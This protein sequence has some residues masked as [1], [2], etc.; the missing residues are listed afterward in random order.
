MHKIHIM[1]A[2]KIIPKVLFIFIYF[3]ANAATHT[4]D[5]LHRLTSVV[6]N[7]SQRIDY[8]YDAAGNLIEER[9]N[10]SQGL[11]VSAQASPAAGGSVSISPVQ[12]GYVAGDTVTATATPSAGYTFTGW[13]G[14]SACT[15][16]SACTFTVPTSSVSL[17]ANFAAPSGL[18]PLRV[19]ALP[20]VGGT[21]TPS[22]NAAGYA[23]GTSITLTATPAAGYVIDY[24]YGAAC[25]NYSGPSCTFSMPAHSSD[26]FV[27]FKQAG[28]GYLLSYASSSP[29]AGVLDIL[30]SQDRIPA[31]AAV[32][33][34][35]LA[36]SGYRFSD[37]RFT[38]NGVYDY[39]I[40]STIQNFFFIPGET[41]TCTFN[42]PASDVAIDVYYTNDPDRYALDITAS[43]MNGGTT[44]ISVNPDTSFAYYYTE[45]SGTATKLLVAGGL[46][47]TLTAKPAGARAFVRWANGP[48]ANSTNPVCTFNMPAVAT[49]SNP[50]FGDEP[51]ASCTYSVSAPSLLFPGT[52][53]TKN[54]T[55][56]TQAG[57]NFNTE[58]YADGNPGFSVSNAGN[59]VTLTVLPHASDFGRRAMLRIHT[60]REVFNYSIAQAGNTSSTLVALSP[61]NLGSAAVGDIPTT[62]IPVTLTN[63]STFVQKMQSP[64]TSGPFAVTS[65]TCPATL[66][67]GASCV[68]NVQFV[69][70]KDGAPSGELLVGASRMAWSAALTATALPT[71]FNVA[72][73]LKGA[74][75]KAQARTG[76]VQYNESAVINGDRRG[77]YGFDQ[78]YWNV[79]AA[80][81]TEVQPIEIKFNSSQTVEW[82]YLFGFDAGNGYT[83]PYP[84]LINT[85]NQSNAGFTVEYWTGASWLAVSELLRVGSPNQWQRV[86]FTPVTTDRVRL[87]LTPSNTQIVVSEIEVWTVAS[88]I[89]PVAFTFAS[90]TDVVPSTVVTSAAVTPTGY[91]VA[92]P[93]SV[94]GGS[95]SIGCGGVF[96]TSAGT[97]EPGQSVCVR[98]TSNAA[99]A[100]TA[101]TTLTIG[102]VSG[103]F[104][105]TT[106]TVVV[107][108]TDVTPDPIAAQSR[109][110]VAP[111]IEINFTAV[112][113]TGIN[114]NAIVSMVNGEFS[115]G[116]NN[117]YTSLASSVSNGASICVRHMSSPSLGQ[118]VTSVLT[119][120]SLNV[121]FSSTTIAQLVAP[122]RLARRDFNHDG[123]SDFVWR[124]MATG[125]TVVA[126]MN[127]LIPT[128]TSIGV[129]GLNVSIQGIGDF[130][131]D[132][133]DDILWRNTST[134]EASISFM[135]GGMVRAWTTVG[136]IS[137]NLVP[138]GVGDYNG[139][140]RDDIVWRNSSTGNIVISYMND[141]NAT[142]STEGVAG[143][144][145]RI[146]GIG[147]FNTDGKADILFRNVS[148][149]NMRILYNTSISS[150][151]VMANFGTIPLEL[152]VQGVGDFNG[153]AKDDILWRNQTTGEVFVSYLEDTVQTWQSLGFVALNL[154]IV[155]VGD[156]NGDGKDDIL[157]RNTNTG[158]VSITYLN[159]ST[160]TWG[161]VG[162]INMGSTI[163]GK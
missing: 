133:K 25:T 87:V 101:T 106:R 69:P 102:G 97:I 145:E 162:V 2:L 64:L 47:T 81:N 77:S 65:N 161:N 17:V 95:Y 41:P 83:E 9:V 142:W 12:S 19:N 160:L 113:I 13:S 27:R 23:P 129:I 153:D 93:I 70:N 144:D 114:T 44:S 55:V 33:L 39:T 130:D 61:V 155:G 100:G 73:A 67:I 62:S 82:L 21:V 159:G 50:V 134:G 74:S 24:W 89:A 110:N 5:P 122:S 29:V 15:T 96:S 53:G 147:D 112:S 90:V 80:S 154:E 71:R 49:V 157:W 163:Y 136:T 60:G 118:T 63:T 94:T 8:V 40:C 150:Q 128:S 124:D 79:R 7:A 52:G 107:V 3:A 123:I 46:S 26:V 148:S 146:R 18:F 85:N 78:S 76:A 111:A 143:I 138:Q 56:T 1:N 120:G 88:D 30:P 115:V 66:A 132:G 109:S 48:C 119:I 31:G 14:Y 72:S 45:A 135:D 43:P 20:S 59:I 57:C 98:H 34:R 158:N 91:N 75:V 140:G 92:T 28:S 11:T 108:P 151:L 38:I 141:A 58:V 22:V 86:K 139:D 4:Y 127:G 104:V 137:L 6:Y 121:G 32:T 10:G 16:N 36:A 42:M 131:G 103:T 68:V 84:P 117:S 54:I 152:G 99:S 51:P 125:N 35:V 116:C 126:L 37:I 105:S 156:Y 149:G